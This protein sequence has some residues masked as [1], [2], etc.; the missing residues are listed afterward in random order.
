MKS[1]GSILKL[2][3]LLS[4]SCLT[5]GKTY[6]FREKDK[7]EFIKILCKQTMFVSAMRG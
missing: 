3:A 2:S 4:L 7:S 1:D 5:G 6:F